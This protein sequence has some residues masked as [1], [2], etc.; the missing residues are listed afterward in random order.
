MTKNFKLLLEEAHALGLQV[1]IIYPEK[2]V[3]EIQNASKKIIVM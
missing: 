1:D 3:V 2:E